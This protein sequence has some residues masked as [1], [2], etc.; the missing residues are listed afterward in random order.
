MG[1]GPP[2]RP[3][4]VGPTTSMLRM[5]GFSALQP[6]A[7]V[8]P[9]AGGAAVLAWRVR[10]T[11]SPVS[12]PRIVIP[13]LAM[14]TGFSMFLLPSFRVPWTWALGAFLFGAL[15]LYYPLAR[16]STLER[17]GDVVMMQR[18][19]AFLAIL[20]ALLAVRIALRGYIGQLVSPRQTAAIF[21][22]LAFGMILRWRVAM[23]R[24]YRRLLDR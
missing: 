21:F 17:R 7:L 22:I 10:E 24:A 23:Y 1:P 4:A 3:P 5:I 9:V 15:V 18:S 14:S 2:R 20:V 11:K 16:T 12:T 8:A 19:R 13:P 6:L